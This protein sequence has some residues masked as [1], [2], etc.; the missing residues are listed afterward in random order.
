MKAIR[1]R[2]EY[3]KEPLGIDIRKPRFFWNCEDGQKQTAYQIICKR[4][5]KTIW[6]SGKVQSDTMTGIAYE[7]EDLRSRD[8]V[9]WAVKLWNEAGEG[10]EIASSRFEMGLLKGG[11]W[12]ANWITGDYKVE[13]KQRYPVDCFRK[14]FK[15]AEVVRAR[16]YITACGVYEARLNGK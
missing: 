16:L 4:A 15:T 7:G 9:S 11:D 13:R 6:D 10:G 1:L 14:T 12:K 8:Q 2:V 3:L 5:G